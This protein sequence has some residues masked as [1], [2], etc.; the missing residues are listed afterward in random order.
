VSGMIDT[1]TLNL[2]AEQ[3]FDAIELDKAIRARMSPP[4]ALNLPELL[5]KRRLEYGLVD[6]MFKLTALYDRIWVWQMDTDWNRQETFVPG[7]KILKTESAKNR[8]RK[9]APVGIVVAA[10]QGARD[11]MRA[12]GCDLGHK[13]AFIRLSPWEMP[14]ALVGTKEVKVMMMRAGDLLGSFDLA[15]SLIAKRSRIELDEQTGQHVYVDEGG[16]RWLPV[17][18]TKN[19]EE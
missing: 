9:E 3:E 16:R 15:E 8:G 14:I 19:F 4:G 10:G 5:E 7:G 1:D 12:H 11:Q 17:D 18:P 2:T 6:E 13:V